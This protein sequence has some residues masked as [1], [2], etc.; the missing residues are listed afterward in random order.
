MMP[1]EDYV[2]NLQTRLT[3]IERRIERAASDVG[4]APT[5]MRMAALD[6]LS[7][8]RIRHDEIRERLDKAKDAHAE[9]WS[10]LHASLQ[11]DVDA[12]YDTLERWML[13]RS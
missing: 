2:A 12:L 3:E 1:K 7:S 10:S 9:D 6:R 11:E 13:D 4:G 8:L 5:E